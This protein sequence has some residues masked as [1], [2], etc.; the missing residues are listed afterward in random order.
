[1]GH[2]GRVRSVWCGALAVLALATTFVVVPAGVSGATISVT[3]NDVSYPNCAAT[4]PST[5][6][7]AVIGVDG[8]V[9]SD[10]NPCLGPNPSY[11]KSELYWA[12]ATSSGIRPQPKASLYVNT[13]DPGN[14]YT[15]T[16][17]ADWPT[18]G[19]TPYGPCTTTTVTTNSGTATVGQNSNACAWEYGDQRAIQDVTWMISAA[20]AL[21][22]L[23]PPVTVPNSPSDYPWWLDVET[24]NTWQTG[25]AGLA[26]NVAALQGIV[27]GLEA[28]GAPSVGVYSTSY[29]WGVITGAPSAS[30]GSLASL[31]TWI[32]G[33]ATAA[34]AEATCAGPSFTNGP[35]ALAQF[36]DGA[37]D[38]DVV[39]GPKVSRVYGSDAIATAIA[40]SQASF[41]APG[42][43]KAVV[44]AR[45]D[46]FSD[47]LAGGPLAAQLGGPLLI[48]PGAS[49]SSSLDPR[50]QAEIQRVLPTG[51]TVYI[52]GGDLALSPSIDTQLQSLGYKTTRIAGANEYAT[53]VDIAEQ[54]GNPSTVFETT[55]LSFYDA[56]SA[57]PAAIATHGAILLTDGA[58]QAPETAA[59]LSA[60]PSDTRYAIGGPLAAAGADP[61]A[62]AIY[63]AN[64]Y[65]TSAAV[66]RT[67]F[68]VPE[69]F[70]A[71]TSAS[72][73]D[74]LSGGPV[75]G[76]ARAPMLL[77]P[78][79]G[80]LPPAVAS[81]LSSYATKLVAG[82]LFGGPLA[83][84]N[85]VL[86]ELN[87]AA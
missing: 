75:L 19:T 51:S 85:D 60:H 83:V 6:A 71:A 13:G 4:W 69:S 12:V 84:G 38:G 48:T 87:A 61:G 2:G 16:A 81:Y 53:A 32:P 28:A 49:I 25:T 37:T 77:V 7:F 63:G 59:Y 45:S 70:G 86:T 35:V 62:T 54:M 64:L 57:V 21:N 1:M 67:F 80:P 34:G 74:A 47:A 9:A 79:T 5:P 33:A 72:F 55:G 36:P 29:Q 52:L 30:V 18:Y 11:T 3:G 42:S 50:V 39:C 10:Q 76:G 44:L 26:M 56:L 20:N 43:A 40:V 65:D 58:T 41:P 27:A 24:V 23:G 73:S 82:T 46:F 8:G 78:S 14:V 15:G 31:E 22:A 68:P 17:I 66:A